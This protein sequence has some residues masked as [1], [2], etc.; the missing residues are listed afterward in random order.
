M[1][2][3]VRLAV[4]GGRH[5]RNRGRPIGAHEKTTVH[6][7]ASEAVRE[8]R[9]EM[10]ARD[11]AQ[12]GRSN[13]EASKANSDIE[14]RATGNGMGR[15]FRPAGHP[16]KQIDQSFATDKNHDASPWFITTSLWAVGHLRETGSAPGTLLRSKRRAMSLTMLNP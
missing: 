9:A 4:I 6:T 16:H 14:G 12:E 11:A 7:F 8:E 13:T 3:V 1:E 10:I 2:S 5:D 15:H